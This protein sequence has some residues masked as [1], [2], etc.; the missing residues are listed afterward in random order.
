MI[1]PKGHLEIRLH[2]PRP[3]TPFLFTGTTDRVLLYVN[4]RIY[5]ICWPIIVVVSTQ[6]MC[7]KAD[8]SQFQYCWQVLQ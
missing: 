8:I 6:M 7:L 1:C 2:S 4:N 3:I 5:I